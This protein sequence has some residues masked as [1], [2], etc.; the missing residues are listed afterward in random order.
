MCYCIIMWSCVSP[1]ILYDYAVTVA[2][3]G[4]CS[5]TFFHNFIMVVC[6]D[7]RVIK[8]ENITYSYWKIFEV[9]NFQGCCILFNLFANK[10]SWISAIISSIV[11]GYY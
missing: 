3:T 5:C 1:I 6:N 8:P 7:I 2:I 10:F 9:Q 4:I 11:S